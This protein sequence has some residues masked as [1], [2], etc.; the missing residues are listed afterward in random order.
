ASL[1]ANS[2]FPDPGL[3]NLS[4]PSADFTIED[5]AGSSQIKT[6]TVTVQWQEESHTREVVLE[7]LMS[8][9]GLNRP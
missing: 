2:T 1:P 9:H 4:N 5:Y 7:T 3:A 8:D 6:A